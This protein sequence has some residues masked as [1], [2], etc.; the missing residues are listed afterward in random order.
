[1]IRARKTAASDAT[2]YRRSNISELRGSLA[3]RVQPTE[4]VAGQRAPEPDEKRPADG[5]LGGRALVACGRERE[6]HVEPLAGHVPGQAIRAFN[7]KDD[8]R[9]GHFGPANQARTH[10]AV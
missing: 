3:Q 1:M 6:L 2:W 8:E 10:S 9:S 7:R 5:E 4:R